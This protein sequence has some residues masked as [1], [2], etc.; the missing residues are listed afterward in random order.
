MTL[1]DGSR[2]RISS[3]R[4]FSTPVR[5]QYLSDSEVID[6]A[7][8]GDYYRP[9]DIRLDYTSNR[10][11]SRIEGCSP[12]GNCSSTLFEYDLLA[13]EQVERNRVVAAS[14]TEICPQAK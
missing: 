12:L 14:L 1:Q 7:R 9:Y 4:A 6:A 11:Y 2:V 5:V 13:R 3:H 8:M 10:L